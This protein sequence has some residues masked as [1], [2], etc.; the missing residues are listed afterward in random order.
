METVLP[1]V[2]WVFSPNLGISPSQ[3][4][5]GF[6]LLGPYRSLQV[7]NQD[8]LSQLLHCGQVQCQCHNDDKQ[9]T[10]SFQGFMQLL[11]RVTNAYRYNLLTKPDLG[12]MSIL[13]LKDLSIPLWPLASSPTSA[14][15]QRRRKNCVERGSS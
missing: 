11:E 9:E 4:A 7:D 3:G 2:Q 6:V 12:F 10:E 15:I 5:K 1:T 13:K 8:E 14:S